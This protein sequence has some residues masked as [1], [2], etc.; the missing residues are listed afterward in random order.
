MVAVAGTRKISRWSAPHTKGNG[1][2]LFVA[3][4]R[5]MCP[6]S[7]LPGE[8]VVFS[9]GQEDAWFIP[10]QARTNHV[11]VESGVVKIL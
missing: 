1:R 6:P 8:A 7:G 2:A 4:S 10:L 9:F 5:H 3:S 11:L